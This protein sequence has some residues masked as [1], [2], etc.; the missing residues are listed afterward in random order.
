MASG[1]LQD[2]PITTAHTISSRL[3]ANTEIP[4]AVVI[5]LARISEL[6]GA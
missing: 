4:I 2:H 5:S 1:L 3:E 6:G